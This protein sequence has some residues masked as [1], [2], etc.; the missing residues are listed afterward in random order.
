MIQQLRLSPLRDCLSYLTSRHEILRTTFG[1]V[2]GRPAQTIHHSSPP[3]LTFID[4]INTVD[5]QAETEAI[6]RDQAS[7]MPEAPMQS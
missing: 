1:V 2:E 7:R 4:L 5:P 6:L 3:N